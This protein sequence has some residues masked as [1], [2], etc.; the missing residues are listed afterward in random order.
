MCVYI[1]FCVK[2]VST[3]NQPP[4]PFIIFMPGMGAHPPYGSPMEYHKMW[5]PKEIEQKAPLRAP[6]GEGKPQ[7]FKKNEGIPWWHNL[8][9]FNDSFFY[10]IAAAYAG[11]QVT[12]LTSKFFSDFIS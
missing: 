4:Q 11:M 9:G 3:H 1:L 8:E 2:N 7:Y 12:M 6:Y 10:D 5:D